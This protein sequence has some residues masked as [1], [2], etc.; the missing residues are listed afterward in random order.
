MLK[1]MLDT[2]NCLIFRAADYMGKPYPGRRGGPLSSGQQAQVTT[3]T[4]LPGLSY[5]GLSG[6][7]Y[8]VLPLSVRH[9]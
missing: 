8:D 5:S 2:Q 4:H 7:A 6:Q 1:K 3:V 9:F